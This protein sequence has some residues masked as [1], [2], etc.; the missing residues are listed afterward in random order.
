MHDGPVL[1][2]G[3]QAQFQGSWLIRYGIEEFTRTLRTRP[4]TWH[5]PEKQT[6]GELDLHHL[7]RRVS[8]YGT[9]QLLPYTPHP[10]PLSRHTLI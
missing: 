9:N 3:I 8:E 4:K 5:L 1:G 7:L 6:S 2:S 10:Y